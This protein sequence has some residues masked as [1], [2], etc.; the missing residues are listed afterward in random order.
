MAEFTYTLESGHVRVLDT[1]K[2]GAVTTYF[3]ED[4]NASHNGTLMVVAS[5]Q[6][7]GYLISKGELSDYS[8]TAGNLDLLVAL[9][10][11]NFFQPILGAAVTTIN[12][13][14][15]AAKRSRGGV[16]FQWIDTKSSNGVVDE[17]FWDEEVNGTTN[18]GLN[19]STGSYDTDASGSGSFVVRQVKAVAPYSTGNSQRIEWAVSGFSLNSGGNTRI[20]YYSSDIASPF[21]TGYDGFMLIANGASADYC[22]EVHR[23]GTLITSLFRPAW[24]DPLDGTGISGKTINFDNYNV[25]TSE[26]A[27]NG[28]GITMNIYIDGDLINFINYKHTNTETG[29]MFLFPQKSI[30]YELRQTAVGTQSLSFFMAS[31]SNEGQVGLD[32]RLLGI[33]SGKLT[34]E[35]IDANTPGDTYAI[36]GIRLKPEFRHGTVFPVSASIYAGTDDEFIMEGYFNPVIAGP[37]LTWTPHPSGNFEFAI[38]DRTN[39]PSQTTITGG[40]VIIPFYG[41]GNS[42]LSGQP[43]RADRVGFKID[44]TPDELWMAVGT[45]DGATG[46]DAFG[47]LTMEIIL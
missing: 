47:S 32:F 23:G 26:F 1:D 19:I 27:Y 7:G 9:Y 16:P 15:D 35:D 10:N 45:I 14:I 29:P 6:Y 41:E 42:V 20:G 36:I 12:Q 5:R 31:V 8:P 3:G 40:T 37:A 46:L 24:D 4:L 39:S 25:V 43:G 44:G 17:F 28:T 2:P 22:F 38:G 21:N 30:R 33:N 11:N 13:T 34:T 18:T